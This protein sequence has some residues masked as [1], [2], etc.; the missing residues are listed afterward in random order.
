[1]DVQEF[2]V[3]GHLGVVYGNFL[4]LLKMVFCQ[5]ILIRFDENWVERSFGK[6]SFGM[7]KTFKFFIRGCLVVFYP[8][9][10]VRFSKC[11][12]WVENK[13]E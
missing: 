6:S 8:Q 4:S 9:L 5:Y 13:H 7:F 2:E 10:G 3:K 12:N 11:S 1:M